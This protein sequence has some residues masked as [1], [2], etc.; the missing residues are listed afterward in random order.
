VTGGSLFVAGLTGEGK[1]NSGGTF[2][3]SAVKLL[4][5]SKGKTVTIEVSYKG[6]DGIGKIGTTSFKVK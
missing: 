5:Q 4:N 1:V 2:D 6:P 3:A